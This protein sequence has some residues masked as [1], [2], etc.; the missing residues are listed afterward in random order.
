MSLGQRLLIAVLGVY[1]AAISPV[2]G[3]RCRFHPTCS[4]YAQEAIREHGALRGTWYGIRRIG[5]CHPYHPGG[6][7]P[8]PG[9]NQ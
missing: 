1:R 9:S 2:L 3:P 5:R 4:A 7:D 8:V 6:Y